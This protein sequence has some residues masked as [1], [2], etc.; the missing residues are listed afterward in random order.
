MEQ[1]HLTTGPPRGKANWR[2][3]LRILGLGALILVLQIPI[4]MIGSIVWERD[5]TRSQAISEVAEKWGRAQRAVGPFLLVPYRYWDDHIDDEKKLSRVERTAV[6]TF[7]PR[8]LRVTGSLDTEV[9]YRGIFETPVYHSRLRFEGSFDRPDFED[10]GID[11]KEILWDRAEAVFEIGDVRAV[12]SASALRWGEAEVDFA[13]GAGMRAAG[14]GGGGVHAAVSLDGGEDSYPFSAELELNGSSLIRFAPTGRQTEVRLSSNWPHPSFQGA[15][16]PTERDVRADGFEAVW[17]VPHLGRNYPQRWYGGT[18]GKSIAESEFGVD[19]FSP[20]DA[21]RQTERSLKYQLLFL[22]L[23]FTTIWLLEV[24]IGPR[25]HWIQYGL[26]GLAMCVFYL[27]ELSIAEH[28]GF[29]AAYAVASTAVVVL[30]A[31]YARVVLTSG[32]RAGVLGVV[33]ACLYGCL[34]VLIQLQ[35]YALLVG[36]L[37]LFVVLAIIM[38]ATRRVDWSVVGTG[39]GTGSEKAPTSAA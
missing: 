4:E 15:W 36:S 6:A 34:Y 16:L 1:S 25:V 26:I 17:R 38:Y 12:Q 23:T 13:P 32:R 20:V 28:F 18:R 3:S 27:L 37:S 9:R 22:V 11:L 24:L 35:D 39:D 21:Y 29:G 7:L 31:S 19:L 10:W 33:I 14:A 8:D 5:E 30:I 2:L